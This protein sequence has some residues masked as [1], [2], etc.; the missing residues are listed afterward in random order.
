MPTFWPRIYPLILDSSRVSAS[1]RF[2]FPA[3]AAEWIGGEAF[4][5]PFQI[6]DSEQMFV[7]GK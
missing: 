7:S 3:P 6:E 5:G 1:R 4:V 2:P